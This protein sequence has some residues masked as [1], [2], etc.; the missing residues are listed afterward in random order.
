MYYQ[1][2]IEQVATT[3]QTRFQSGFARMAMYLLPRLEDVTYEPTSIGLRIL[4]TDETALSVPA[5]ILVEIYGEGIRLTK[6]RVRMIRDA[7]GTKEPIM[8]IR[9]SAPL[10]AQEMVLHDLEDRGT[11]IQEV[12]QQL[13]AVVI[14]GQAPLRTLLGYQQ[15]L[16]SMTANTAHLW[17]WLSHYA[18]IPSLDGPA[19]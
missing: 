2:P 6:P 11:L 18:S 19:A 8:N 5:E 12:E 13:E 1:F 15:V 9:I 14:R 7:E 17:V 4:G 3:S 10:S 16:G